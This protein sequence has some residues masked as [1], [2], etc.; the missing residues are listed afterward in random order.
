MGQRNQN[1]LHTVNCQIRNT[2][3]SHFYFNLVILKD[4]S[5]QKPSKKAKIWEKTFNVK[6]PDLYRTNESGEASNRN[7]I[8]N[9][10]EIKMGVGPMKWSQ[11][12]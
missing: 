10:R 1:E 7:M 12:C 2:D 3:N 4:V 6:L 8:E 5:Q 9:K 11:I